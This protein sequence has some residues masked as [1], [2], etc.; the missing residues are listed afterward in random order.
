MSDIT[1]KSQEDKTIE[2]IIKLFHVMKSHKC[3]LVYTK[4]DPK[5]RVIVFILIFLFLLLSFYLGIQKDWFG[6]IIIFLGVLYSLIVLFKPVII[7]K[8]VNMQFILIGVP[9]FI[10]IANIYEGD[11]SYGVSILLVTA[12]YSGLAIIDYPLKFEYGGLIRTVATVYTILMFIYLLYEVST[13][14]KNNNNI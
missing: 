5:S 10:F 1:I 11:K 12:I 14:V 6:K 7:Q 13:N 8:Q 9:L 3:D 4:T 2:K